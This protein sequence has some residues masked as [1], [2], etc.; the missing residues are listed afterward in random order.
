MV[1]R[2]TTSPDPAGI[3]PPAVLN[4]KQV[5]AL[6]GVSVRHVYRLADGGLM[7]RPLKLGGLNRR[8]KAAIETWLADGAQPV[9]V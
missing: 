2:S 8:H 9:R 6:L 3:V 1:A 4:V 7:P 5:A